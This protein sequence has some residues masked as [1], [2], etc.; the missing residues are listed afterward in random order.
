MKKNFGTVENNPNVTFC[1]FAGKT[2]IRD[3][4]AYCSVLGV[5]LDSPEKYAASLPFSLN[6]ATAGTENELQSVVLGSRENVDLPLKIQESNYIKNIRKRTISGEAPPEALSDLEKFLESNEDGVWEN[7]WVRFPGNLLNSYAENIFKTDLL[8]DKQNPAGPLRSDACKFNI[9]VGGKDYIS[10]P[11]SYL[12]KLALAQAL[13]ELSSFAPEVMSVGRRMM[14]HFS[15][16]NTSPE[17][18]SFHISD[19]HPKKGLGRSVAAETAKRFLFCQVLM[20]YA[21]KKFELE[22]HGQEALVYMAP[23]PPRRLK[24]LNELIA[25]SFYRDLFMSPCLSGWDQGE[26]KHEYMGLCHQVLSRSQLNAVL[27]LKEAGIVNNGL[28]VLP[29][30]SNICLANNG[31]HIS[32]GSRK[33]GEALRDPASGFSFKDEKHLGDLAIKTAEHFLPLFVGTYSAAPY[34]LDYRDFHPEKV[35]GF[36]PHELDFTHLRMIWR[37]WKKKAKFKVLGRPL[38]PFGPAWMDEPLKRMFR[39]YGDYVQDFRL[40]DYLVCLMSTEQSPALDGTSGAEARLKQDLNAMGVFDSRM[41]LYLLYKLREY[42][43]MG[44]SGFEGRHYSLFES[45]KSDLA[46]AASMQNLITAF[47]YHRILSGKI[48]HSRIPDNPFTESERRQ[49]FFGAAIGIP[50]FYVHKK[51]RNSFLLE[52]LK[53]VKGIRNSRRYPGY[54]RV[55]NR[56]YCLGLIRLIKEEGAELIDALELRDVVQDL[57]ARTRFPEAFSAAGKLTGSILERAGASSPMKLTGAEFARAS[58]GYYRDALRIKHMVE[59]MDFFEEDLEKIDGM[60]ILDRAG[61]RRAVNSV[62]DNQS[63]C[64]FFSRIRTDLLWGDVLPSVMERLIALSILSVQSHLPP[65]KAQFSDAGELSISSSD[66]IEES[67][68]ALVNIA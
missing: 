20:Q 18:F 9:K 42:N 15:N 21:N 16:D 30:T 45:F 29:N 24:E 4:D 36:L 51:T 14:D 27:K 33:L 12:L 64:S 53:N 52:I 62:L 28:I 56:Q 68:N 65:D 58:E 6:D 17:T 43:V 32:L 48:S 11:V 35:L 1:D 57:E 67:G 50:T 49:I 13:G 55:H 10:I 37:R 60:A 47:A 19:L 54:L 44:F 3:L 8:A 5:N 66:Q 40:I 41:S 31:T 39:L 38:T 2:E 59:G 61:F 63:A 46:N 26:K 7:S 34:R 25:D 22:K 23:N